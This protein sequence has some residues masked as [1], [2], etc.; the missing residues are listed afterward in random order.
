[1]S[2]RRLNS[3]E[4]QDSSPVVILIAGLLMLGIGCL[5]LLVAVSY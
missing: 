1:M 3:R 2:R 5:A 4:E